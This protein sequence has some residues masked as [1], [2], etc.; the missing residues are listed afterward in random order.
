M[1]YTKNVKSNVSIVGMDDYVDK[2]DY[3]CEAECVQD[4][5]EDFLNLDN[6]FVP[7]FILHPLYTIG[8]TSKDKYIGQGIK[9]KIIP[10]K[11]TQHCIS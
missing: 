10:Q 7:F 1:L 3:D 6:K 8:N 11:D 4:E 9:S 5:E 2:D